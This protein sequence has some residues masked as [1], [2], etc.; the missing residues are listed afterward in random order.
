MVYTLL[1]FSSKCSLFHN[2][3]IF[4]SCV[5]HI[6]YTG[7]AKILKNN[8]DAKRLNSTLPVSSHQCCMHF[9]SPPT[10]TT[11]AYQLRVSLNNTL[12]SSLFPRTVL[13]LAQL[14]FSQL[15]HKCLTFCNTCQFITVY[16]T[17]CKYHLS[18]VRLLQSEFT[19]PTFRI[20]FNIVFTSTPCSS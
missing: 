11:Y 7:C 13:R 15:V 18:W 8:S 12:P 1:F 2:S 6:L 19:D 3:N 14:I 16:T 4:G 5:I 9:H 17:P 10:N 20:S